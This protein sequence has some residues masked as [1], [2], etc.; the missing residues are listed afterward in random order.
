MLSPAWPSGGTASSQN[1]P[2]GKCHGLGQQGAQP[3]ARTSTRGERHGPS[4]SVATPCLWPVSSPQPICC[5]PALLACVITSVHLLQ[6]RFVG[7]CH[8]PSP[9]VAIP[10]LLASVIILGPSL[11]TLAGT[12]DYLLKGTSAAH[13]LPVLPGAAAA[14]WRHALFRLQQRR[15]SASCTGTGT[16]SAAAAKR[17]RRCAGGRA[18]I[19]VCMCVCA[20]AC[21]CVCAAWRPSLV[22]DAWE[23]LSTGLSG[24]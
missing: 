23:S 1:R 14:G 22:W 10:R 20:R 21:V 12:F 8:H 18:C 11:A 4:P 13:A 5:S 9:S 7:L 16:S 24:Q 19:C 15:A 6:P 3:A 2:F 17:H